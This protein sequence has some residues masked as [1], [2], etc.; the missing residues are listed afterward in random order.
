MHTAARDADA[1]APPQIRYF[2]LTTYCLLPIACC[3]LLSTA[4][5][6]AFVFGPLGSVFTAMALTLKR[7]CLADVLSV[8][9]T[10]GA[11]V[12]AAVPAG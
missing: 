8:F 4:P 11:P 12:G 7:D 10:I 9:V 2:L 6:F 3:L 5:A 1:K